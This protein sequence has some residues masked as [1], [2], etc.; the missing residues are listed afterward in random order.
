MAAAQT[1]LAGAGHYVHWGVIQISLTNFL[2]IA[3]MV[4]VF[5][6]AL[7]V[8][9]PGAKEPDRSEQGHDES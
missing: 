4:V 3:G 7:I 5:I 2:I 9:F 8:P 6:L 1:L